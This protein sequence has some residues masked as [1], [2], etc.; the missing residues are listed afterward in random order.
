MTVN[1]K[2]IAVKNPRLFGRTQWLV[3]TKPYQIPPGVWLIF[4][5]SLVSRIPLILNDLPPYQFCDE[6]IYQNEVI[7][8]VGASDW[9]PNEFR[10]G[11]FNIYPAF[12]IFKAINFFL[13]SPLSSL[14][15]LII[16]R[17]FY[18]VLLPSISIL[19]TFKISQLFVGKVPAI[20]TTLIFG[21]STFHYMNFWYPDSYIQFSVLGFLYFALLIILKKNEG[22]RTYTYLGVFLSIAVSTKYTA[23]ALFG[24]ALLLLLYNNFERNGLSKKSWKNSLI[25]IV[26][27]CVCTILLNIGAVI[28]TEA[29]FDGFLFNLNNYVATDEKRYDGFLYYFGI[30]LFNSFGVFGLIYFLIGLV[31]SRSNKLVILFLALYPIILVLLLGDKRWVIARNMSSASVFLIPFIALG[32]SWAMKKIETS[33]KFLE[34]FLYALVALTIFV[35]FVSY[36]YLVVKDISVD[37]RVTAAKWISST[38]DK[39]IVIGVNEF[40]S[41]QSPAQVAGNT[42]KVDPAFTQNLAY[43]V[44]NSY[45]SSPFSSQ[46]LEKGV[47]LLVDQSKIHFEQWN[48]TKLIG[49]LGAIKLSHENVPKNY[50]IRKV[51]RGNGPDIIILE[52]QEFNK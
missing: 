37:T 5:M 29:F 14:Q 50:E 43:Y 30:L 33:G 10:A 39:D 46:Y 42:I 48:S 9:I 34:R 23:V 36:T 31:S 1:K 28:R 38:I 41:G 4:L 11:G 7:R 35:P 32:V 47:L 25:A 40:C 8:M 19:F 18:V 13:P 20:I 22:A 16:G 52:H 24:P 6:A 44:L 26:M 2:T 12:I 49:S 21:T 3:G 17:I 51:I 15:M 45:W 27:F